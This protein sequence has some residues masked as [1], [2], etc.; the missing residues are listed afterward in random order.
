MATNP[1]GRVRPLDGLGAERRACK[2]GRPSF[3]R[4]RLA[5]HEAHHDFERVLQ[6][7]KSLADR[8]KSDAER[9][10]LGLEPRGT[11]REVKTTVGDM[12]DGDCL[13]AQN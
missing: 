6:Q 1:D 5:A 8:G 2:R 7:V 9:T 10:M 3:E 12:V 11:E 13:R 4:D